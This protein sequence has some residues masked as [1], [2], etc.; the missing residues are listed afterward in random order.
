MNVSVPPVINQ[1]ENAMTN[2][3]APGDLTVLLV[4]GAFADGSSWTP[5]IQRLHKAGISVR[6]LAT[7]MRSLSGDAAYVASV[8][9]QTQGRVLLVGHSYGGAVI[10]NAATNATNV[11]GLVYVAAFAPD[12]G[13]T[14]NDI[15]SASKDAILGP[16]LRPA[17]YPI[18]QGNETAVELF[19]DPAA[20]PTV[21]AADLPAEAAVAPAATQR[22]IAAAAFA[23][24]SGTPA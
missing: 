12:E 3:T 11:V 14:L 7:A 17:Q 23:E 6:G 22:P 18:G 13:E 19:A 8:I 2:A 4:H 16:A 24:K 10:S 15:T 5:V 9:A 1:E 21:F 20:F